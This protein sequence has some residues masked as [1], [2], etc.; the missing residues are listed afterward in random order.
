MFQEDEGVVYLAEWAS[1]GHL[2]A[3]AAQLGFDYEADPPFSGRRGRKRLA[4]LDG[5]ERARTGLAHRIPGTQLSDYRRPRLGC[6]SPC[7]AQNRRPT[8]NARMK[9]MTRQAQKCENP[10]SKG[11]LV[12]ELRGFEP[13]TP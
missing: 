6:N 1:K 7:N 3:T 4:V 13:L 9:L 2:E 11:S 5:F 8:K 12:V 10:C